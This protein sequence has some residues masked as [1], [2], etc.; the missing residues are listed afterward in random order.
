MVQGDFHM[1]RVAA[2]GGLLMRCGINEQHLNSM[3]LRLRKRGC[4]N[5]RMQ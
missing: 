2:A 3:G 4:F 1:R 5:G